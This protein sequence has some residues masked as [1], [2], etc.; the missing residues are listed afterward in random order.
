MEGHAI[1]D[2]PTALCQVVDGSTSTTMHILPSTTYPDNNTSN[3]DYTVF[4][5]ARCRVGVL[6]GVNLRGSSISCTDLESSE[7]I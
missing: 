4:S 7:G 2:K 3:E 1:R 6:M 5:Y